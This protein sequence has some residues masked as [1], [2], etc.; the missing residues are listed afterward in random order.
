M[1]PSLSGFKK[2]N[3]ELRK[4][5][6]LE[7]IEPPRI[8]VFVEEGHSCVRGADTKAREGGVAREHD[9]AAAVHGDA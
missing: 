7:Y 5:A 8:T 3:A 4:V 1:E 9:G 2:V 6:G